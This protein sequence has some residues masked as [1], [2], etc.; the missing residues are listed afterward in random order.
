MDFESRGWRSAKQ[1]VIFTLTVNY[2]LNIASI[3][4][5]TFTQKK[6]KIASK[7]KKTGKIWIKNSFYLFILEKVRVSKEWTE[8]LIALMEKHGSKCRNCNAH[9]AGM[10][11]L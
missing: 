6:K 2:T 1:K 8:L 4:T 10:K 9:G 7:A 5:E 11:G 3:S